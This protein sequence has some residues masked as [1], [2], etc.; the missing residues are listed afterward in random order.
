MND[1]G[2]SPGG[3][4]EGPRDPLGQMAQQFAELNERLRAIAQAGQDASVWTGG[5]DAQAAFRSMLAQAALPASALESFVAE[6]ALRREQ[7]RTLQAQLAAFDEQ[8]HRLEQTLLPLVQWATTWARV[9]R[10]MLGPLARETPPAE[11]ERASG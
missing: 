11:G 5:V 3:S 2:G 4:A 9:Q 6:I 10:A 7:L 8:L 1:S